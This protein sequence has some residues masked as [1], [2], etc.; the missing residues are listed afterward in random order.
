MN[1]ASLNLCIALIWTHDWTPGCTKLI[2]HAGD[3]RRFRPY[4]CKVWFD[5]RCNRRI[6]GA[7]NQGA[8]LGD[9]RI[10]R[11][12][13]NLVTLAREFPCQRVL[14]PSASDDENPHLKLPV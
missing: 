10:A 1:L 7:R 9:S 5:G 11:C 6:V 12:G 4:N 8:Y 14:A 13:E 2:D 3:Q